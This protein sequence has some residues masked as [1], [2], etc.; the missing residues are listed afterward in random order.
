MITNLIATIVVTLVTNV[1]ERFPQHLEYEP[2]PDNIS[3]C[4]VLHGAHYVNDANPS[5]KWVRTTVTRRKVA[6][7]QF[8]ERLVEPVLSDGVV[9]DT[10][11]EYA[12][13][14]TET[15]LPKS[16]N[17]VA[18][19][20]LDGGRWC[21]VIN[22]T[23]GMTFPAEWTNRNEILLGLTNWLT[24]TNNTILLGP[25]VKT[26]SE[27]F[28]VIKKSESSNMTTITNGFVAV[29]NSSRWNNER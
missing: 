20:T 6:Q 13:Q 28:I 21:N 5:K 15:W 12:I 14:R 18:G 11:V 26:N 10:E 29:T 16:T 3:G 23:N 7:I 8:E 19:K 2:C 9:S 17:D 1:T 24:I 25:M 4:L 27:G 22:A